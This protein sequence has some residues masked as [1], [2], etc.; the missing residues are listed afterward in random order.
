MHEVYE[1]NDRVPGANIN[2][3]CHAELEFLILQYE[4]NV[5]NNNMGTSPWV[6]ARGCM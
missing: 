4:S 1:C 3:H 6:Y 2:S 5:I